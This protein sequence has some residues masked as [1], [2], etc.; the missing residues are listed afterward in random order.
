MHTHVSLIDADGYNVFAT[1]DVQHPPSAT[2]QAF[3][4]GILLHAPALTA[5]LNPTVNAYKRLAGAQ[6]SLAPSHV[7]WGLDNRT[8]F[9]RIPAER[10]PLPGLSCAWATPQPTP[11]WLSPRSWLQVV[12]ES[13]AALR[14]P[15]RSRP[16][17]H[18]QD[19]S[20]PPP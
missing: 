5:L 15:R 9:V 13:N 16:Q 19:L 14:H 8:A 7:N 6:D 2:A 17:N 12:T 3:L 11:T 18:A 20:C 1:D 10:G 4:A